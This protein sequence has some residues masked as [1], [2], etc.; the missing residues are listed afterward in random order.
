MAAAARGS[1]LKVFGSDNCLADGWILV[2]MELLA[3]TDS[4]LESK[5]GAWAGRRF[6][7]SSSYISTIKAIKVRLPTRLK[8]ASA[9][10]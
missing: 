4:N 5:T 7:K 2:G 9:R 10:Q 6:A 3:E 1:V 8:A